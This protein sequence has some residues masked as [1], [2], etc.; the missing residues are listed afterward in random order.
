MDIFKNYPTKIFINR[1]VF[2]L[3]HNLIKNKKE[4]IEKLK[5]F[6]NLFNYFFVDTKK[7]TTDMTSKFLNNISNNNN[8]LMYCI[9][10]KKKLI[11]QYGMKYSGKK[12]ISLDNAIRFSSLGGKKIFNIIEKKLLNLIVKNNFG[13]NIIIMVNKKNLAAINMHKKFKFKDAKY[14][15][16]VTDL[17]T[18][19]KHTSKKPE[20]YF[21]KAIKA[22]K[23][24]K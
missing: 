9:F 15:C 11:G 8:H 19:I 10:Y 6:R 2:C 22:T 1:D 23:R 16:N 4:H 21:I 13:Y 5:Q 20:D 3:Q 14:V 17:L 24:F 12:R 18:Y 7:T